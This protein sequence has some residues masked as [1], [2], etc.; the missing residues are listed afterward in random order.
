MS[1][2]PE[3]V[4]VEAQI[5]H[6]TRKRDNASK[7]A[8]QVRKDADRQRAKLDS[9][10]RDLQVVQTAADAA[11]GAYMRLYRSEVGRLMRYMHL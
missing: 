7:I 5:A 6:S 3:L 1:Q 11:Q 9:L 10:R 8:E 2:R 4:Q